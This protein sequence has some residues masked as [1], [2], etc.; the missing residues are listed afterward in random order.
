MA[1]LDVCVSGQVS[2]VELERACIS[3]V[4]GVLEAAAVAVPES[5]SGPD[6]L[7][8]FVVPSTGRK[9]DAKQLQRGCQKAIRENINPLFKLQKVCYQQI[10]FPVSWCSLI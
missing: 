5:G 1:K 6:Q 10:A 2:A 4:A 7:V 8:M 3:G 9:V